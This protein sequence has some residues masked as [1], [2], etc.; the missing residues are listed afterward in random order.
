VRNYYNY[1]TEVE[2]YFV[3]KRGKNLMIAPLD[4]CLVELWK[5]QKIPLHIV[6]RGIDRSFESAAQRQRKPPA[7][8]YYCHPAV[9]EAW[10]EYQAAAVGGH[11][12]DAAEGS[13]DPGYAA[14]VLEG[15]IRRL[16]AMLE[17]SR[18]G[19][20][21]AE[22]QLEEELASLQAALVA[23][24]AD[25]IDRVRRRRLEQEIRREVQRYRKRLSPEVA[26]RLQQKYLERRLREEL[27]LPEFSLLAA[28]GLGS[29][30][31]SG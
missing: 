31:P 3:R 28:D 17:D 24:L 9:M 25:S 15:L 13:G 4:W 1:F 29:S 26:A 18:R 27:G 8:L 14:S 7:T 30:P 12:T 11:Q 2:E 16:E 21:L 22:P 23:E 10:E 19:V 6:L 20:P 5:E